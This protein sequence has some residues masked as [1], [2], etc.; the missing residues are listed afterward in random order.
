MATAIIILKLL[1]YIEV[2]RV[3]KRQS[4]VCGAFQVSQNTHKAFTSM[5]IL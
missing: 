5:G 2:K 3:R 1:V 4:N